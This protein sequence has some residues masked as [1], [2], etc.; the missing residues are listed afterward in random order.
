MPPLAPTSQVSLH[1]R[2]NGLA[3]ADLFS[4]SDPYA[5]ILMGS[6][7]PREVG[8]TEVIKNSHDPIWVK[9]TLVDY[10]FEQEQLVTIRVAD[11]D[12]M[13]SDDFMGQCS[14][15]LASLVVAPGQ[16]LTLSL[17]TP[18]GK[19]GKGTITVTG[20]EAAY[21]HD[22][23]RLILAAQKLPNEKMFGKSEAFYILERVS[24]SGSWVP[25]HKSEK[26]TKPELGWATFKISVQL[27]CNGDHQRPLRVVMWDHKSSGNH[28][29]MCELETNL[30]TILEQQGTTM[31]LRNVKKGKIKGT[32]LVKKAEFF[33]EPTLLDYLAGGM[34]VNMIVAIDFTGSNGNPRTPG[35][36]HY[37]D[38]SGRILN[39][40]QQA[41]LSIGNVLQEYDSDRRF[42]VF[43]FG[44]KLIPGGPAQHCFPICPQEALARGG[45]VE[46]V[47]GIMAAYQAAIQTVGLSGPTL[48]SEIIRT[49]AQ[50]AGH[51]I[52]QAEQHY[53]ILLILTDGVINDMQST[54]DA[55]VEASSLPLSIIIV[56]VGSA[57]FSLMHAL[58]S[59]HAA[60]TDSRG[61]ESTRDIV[62]FVE[63]NRL[64]P[65]DGQI[66]APGG[67][68]AQETLAELP[69]QL[70]GAMKQMRIR[71]N[72]A[73]TAPPQA[74]FAPPL[75]DAK[76]LFS[77]ASAPPALPSYAE[78]TGYF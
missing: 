12:K 56:G 23:V 34:Q 33:Q 18:S 6:Q 57:D 13:T 62:Q 69:A 61:K 29:Y 51:H 25:V 36:L 77:D 78:A 27:L 60:L 24:E 10:S 30:A 71:P 64:K 11:E 70:L 17:T 4:K 15:K 8:R 40:Y 74:V 14:F 72:P 39:E 28:T 52:S 58:D 7:R 48:F 65:M 76:P 53:T 19:R 63:F 67:G 66:A 73:R 44:G 54:V 35:T 45:E 41:I 43:G 55:I 21:V 2:A 47:A 16:T 26:C 1:L 37:C 22:Y 3:R 42:P 68:L 59:D 75:L 20:E 32:L 49:A 50:R 9:S 46:G 31:P 5:C 38:P